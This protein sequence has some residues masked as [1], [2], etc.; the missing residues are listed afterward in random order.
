MGVVLRS[1]VNHLAGMFLA[2]CMEAR[3]LAVAIDARQGSRIIGFVGSNELDVPGF[4]AV[5]GG[6]GW[7]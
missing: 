1:I 5:V 2:A 6:S 3:Q 7:A 4:Q